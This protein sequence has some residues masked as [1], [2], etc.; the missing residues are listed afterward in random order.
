LRFAEAF[1]E[2]CCVRPQLGIG[3]VVLT[4]EHHHELRDAAGSAKQ[5]PYAG[6]NL[7]EPEEGS[8]CGIHPDNTPS[9]SRRV[10]IRISPIERIFCRA[11]PSAR[12][13]TSHTSRRTYMAEFLLKRAPRYAPNP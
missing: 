8:T 9:L 13:T 10:D 7:V 1:E 2:A 11:T 4:C 3:C 6:T 5:F 12:P